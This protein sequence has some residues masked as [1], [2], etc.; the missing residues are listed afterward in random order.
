MG[1]AHL[2]TRFAA[3]LKSF[4]IGHEPRHLL[5]AFSGGVDSAVLLY[6]LRFRCG[7]IPLILTAAHLDHRMRSS[8]ASDAAW[9]QGL[10]HAWAVPLET[11]VA[12]IDLRSEAQA[13]TARYHFL[14]NAASRV[15][16][17][18]IVTAHHADDQ[19]ETVLFRILRGTG[20]HGLG[21]IPSRTR[22][23]LIRPMLS[24]WRSEIESYA[25]AR[26]IPWRIDPSNATHGPTRNRL[27]LKIL[28]DIER[29]ISTASR[30]NLVALAE[31]ARESE[32]AWRVLVRSVFD[33]AIVVDGD[34][35]VVARESL[36]TYHPAIASRVVRKLLRRFGIVP[37]RAGTRAALKFI[38]D[39]PS[40]REMQ[41]PSGV[42][43]RVEFDHAQVYRE[44]PIPPD[45]TLSIPLPNGEDEIRGE[46]L[47]AGQRYEVEARF[48][49]HVE[50]GETGYRWRAILPVDPVRF[51]LTIRARASGDR[52][53]TR[54]GSRSLKKLMIDERLPVSQRA[55]R[56]VLA[57]NA[58]RVLWVAGLGFDPA[59]SLTHDSLLLHLSIRDGR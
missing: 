55:T 51:P 2:E 41:L 4:E 44:E 59:Q 21:G 5:V 17:H 18:H 26:G 24:F 20:L 27:R 52:I 19:A 6:L 45:T 46:V 50:S 42:R 12:R 23:G 36:A 15:A 38:T 53:Q 9:V 58:G 32:A 10:C 14:R 30:R 40:G 56:P 7:G 11:E 13:R 48:A 43:I 39:A 34:T 54:V 1:D 8:S 49:A 16:A 57:D 25:A 35:A 33:Q 47:L 28:P 31:L 3:V 37:D 22:S 29:E